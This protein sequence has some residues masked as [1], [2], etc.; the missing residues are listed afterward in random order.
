M[1]LIPNPEPGSVAP[2]VWADYEACQGRHA[3]FDGLRRALL[4]F[5]SALRAA[6]GMYDEIIGNGLLD[7]TLKEQVCVACAGV[8]DCAYGI[9]AHGQ[10]LAQHAG[11]SS[12]DVD[13]IAAGRT[14]TTH[15]AFEKAILAFSRK[16]A[17]APYRTVPSDL[18][19]LR[20]TGGDDRTIIE[21]ITVVSL[22]GWM[23]GYAMALGLDANDVSEANQTGETWL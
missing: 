22:S 17:T 13:D 1:A 10:W 18:D 23:N 4:R 12:S 9:A 3:H 7:R 5:P 19:G 16:V 8:R 11:F 20:D 15:S 2:E 14:P 21:T 6:D